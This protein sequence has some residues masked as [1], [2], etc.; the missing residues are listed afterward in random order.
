ML[1]PWFKEVQLGQTGVII[2]IKEQPQLIYSN[3]IMMS[4]HSIGEHMLKKTSIDKVMGVINKKPSNASTLI[5]LDS[6]RYGMLIKNNQYLIIFNSNNVKL[7]S[8][9]SGDVFDRLINGIFDET[10]YDNSIKSIKKIFTQV[11]TKP[12]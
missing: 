3:I 8:F 11:E 5:T 7:C 12:K 9:E 4:L 10:K 1:E 2:P 6:F